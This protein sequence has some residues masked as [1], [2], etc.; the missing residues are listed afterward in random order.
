MHL[1]AFGSIC[2][3]EI[4]ETSDIDLL[5]IVNGYDERLDPKIYSIYSYKRIR[6]I[7]SEGNPFAWHLHLEARSLF[8]SDGVDYLKRLGNPSR[9]TQCEIDCRKFLQ[10]FFSSKV[11]LLNSS[12]SIV[13]DLSTIF[14]VC[15]T[16]LRAIH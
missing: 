6:E 3:G 14:Y 7:W 5:A 4:L 15:A 11:S 10:L 12:D 16:L 8:L 9:Y 1:Y 2:R 13:F